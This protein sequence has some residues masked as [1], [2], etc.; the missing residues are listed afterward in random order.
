M[1]ETIQELRSMSDDEL[2]SRHDA[3]AKQT[4]VGTQ[5]YLNEL[6]RRDLDRQ[7][8][9]M[10]DYTKQVVDYTKQVRNFTIAI[11]ILTVVNVVIVA[12][13]LMAWFK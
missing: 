3:G 6:A 9:A 7:T 10:L 5:H 11:V 1:A 13:P 4:L 8:G 12:I 2:I